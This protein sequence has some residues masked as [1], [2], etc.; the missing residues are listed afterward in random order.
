VIDVDFRQL[1]IGTKAPT[2]LW[3]PTD[4]ATVSGLPVGLQ[5]HTGEQ[6]FDLVV[7][8]PSESVT[9]ARFRCLGAGSPYRPE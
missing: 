7:V 1:P 9:S 6:S 8:N 4:N 3:V 5:Q 2:L